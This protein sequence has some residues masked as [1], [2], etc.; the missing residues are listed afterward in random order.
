MSYK[1][2]SLSFTVNIPWNER[3]TQ[4]QSAVENKLINIIKH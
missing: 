2:K 4:M 1:N 3:H